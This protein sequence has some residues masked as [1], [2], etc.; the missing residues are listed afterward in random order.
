LHFEEL[1]TT[2]PLPIKDD[3]T[4]KATFGSACLTK[5]QARIN[6]V[7]ANLTDE[8]D[9]CGAIADAI[10]YITDA[11]NSDC[12]LTQWSGTDS[13]TI[14]F[15]A[16]SCLVPGAEASG[17]VIDDDESFLISAA[18][19]DFSLYDA[20]VGI[21]GPM[22]V[23]VAETERDENGKVVKRNVVSSLVCVP[24]DDVVNGSRQLSGV[25]TTTPSTTA[26]S[27][28]A[29]STT[30]PVTPTKTPGAAIR[31]AE[32]F[33]FGVFAVVGLTVLFGMSI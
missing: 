6:L 28:T 15:G 20:A 23:A 11:D 2:A 14:D 1:N 32:G 25:N 5:I 22:L 4:C 21:P 31:G 3:G 12:T 24:A 9:V 19:D 10:G 33:G 27:T 29:P 8:Y 13:H 26:P 17:H 7:H 30:A 16:E 18:A